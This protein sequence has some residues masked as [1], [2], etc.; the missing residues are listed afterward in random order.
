MVVSKM[1]ELQQHPITSHPTF[2]SYSSVSAVQEKEKTQT[3]NE[4]HSY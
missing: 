1:R 4:Q 3:S 2:E